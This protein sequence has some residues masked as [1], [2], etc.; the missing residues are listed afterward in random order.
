[1][2]GFLYTLPHLLV[3]KR[4][5]GGNYI[6]SGAS[7]KKVDDFIQILMQSFFFN[8]QSRIDRIVV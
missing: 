5:W 4:K 6:P 2:N 3:Y 7:V 8:F 1:M